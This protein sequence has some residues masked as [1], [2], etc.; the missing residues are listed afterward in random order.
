M[1]AFQVLFS[2]SLLSVIATAQ[3]VRYNFSADTDFNKFKTYKWIQI[4]NVEPPD[5]LTDQQIKTAID[6]ELAK[7][8]LRRVDENEPA[9]LLIG[10]QV[11]TS[12]EKQLTMYNSDWGYGPGWGRGWYGPTGG[13]ST[14][15]TSTIVIG[16]LDLDMYDAAAKDLVWRGTASKTLDTKAKPE[17]RQKNLQKGVAKL[18]KNYPPEKKVKG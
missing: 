3:D 15:Q 13:M 16:Q 2:V 8:G 17:K 1:K 10:Y 5:Q 7:K 12:S 11:S 18:L 6:T 9:D 4:R 14:G